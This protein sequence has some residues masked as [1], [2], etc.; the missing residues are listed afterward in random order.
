[1]ISRPDGRPSPATTVADA[2]A[3][4]LRPGVAATAIGDDLLLLDTTSNTVVTVPA[5]GGVD[6]TAA[7]LAHHGL[8]ANPGAVSRRHLLAA[9]AAA[10]AAAITVMA[11]PTAAAAASS[12]P[13]PGPAP[14]P[15]TTT[16]VPAPDPVTALAVDAVAG[17]ATELQA[18]WTAA[19]GATSYVVAKR[20]TGATDFVTVGTTTDTQ[21]TI[22]SLDPDTTYDIS[23]TATSSGGSSDPGIESA[24]TGP[25]A[26]GGTTQTITVG[27]TTYRVHTFTSGGTF[28]LNTSAALEYLIVAGGGGGGSRHGGG[29]GAGGLLTNVGS[30]SSFNAASYPVSVGA[31]GDGMFAPDD[32]TNG[33]N[34]TALGLTAIGGGRGMGTFP[35][36]PPGAGGSGGGSNWAGTPGGSGTSGQ[37][38]NGGLGFTGNPGGWAGGGGGGAGALGGDATAYNGGNGGSGQASSITGTSVTYAGGGGGSGSSDPPTTGSGGAGG[39]GGGGAGGID[40]A[41]GTAGT[42]GLGGGGG[43]GGFVGD[44]NYPGGKGGSGIVVIRYALPA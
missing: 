3:P 5:T 19:P 9:G 6:R 15:T 33:E 43:A 14:E 12:E 17:N 25:I 20:E 7:V 42:D 28:T 27:A 24:T 29:G 32:S 23:V 38:K 34:S 13:G 35:A 8:L 11:L 30:P 41:A 4:L 36:T 39:S 26:T 10:G 16:T 2:I 1:M 31:G 37:G 22:G 21:F 44:T 18:S 40:A